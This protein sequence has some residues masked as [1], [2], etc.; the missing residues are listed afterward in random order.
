M[1]GHVPTI[2]EIQARVSEFHGV[3]PADLKSQR[4]NHEWRRP[5]H[6]AMYLARNL[7]HHS[8]PAIG[9][10]FGG[11][12]HSTV[13]HACRRIEEIMRSDAAVALEI[14]ALSGEL[15]R[16]P[17]STMARAR[18]ACRKRRKEI[19]AGI[20]RLQG[21]LRAL[22]RAEAALDNA[23]AIRWPS[24]ERLTALLA[25]ILDDEQGGTE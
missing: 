11:R 2:R 3:S 23:A 14:E 5:R 4:R 8:F 7:T 13:I 22:E 20:E 9:Q 25:E 24:E 18:Q 6:I 1:S 17:E 21:A 12:D 15:T 16:G 10:Q 19:K